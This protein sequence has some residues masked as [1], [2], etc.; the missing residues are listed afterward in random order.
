MNCSGGV[1]SNKVICLTNSGKYRIVRRKTHAIGNR[2]QGYSRPQQQLDCGQADMSYFCEKFL[3]E[4]L[5]K[6]V[7]FQSCGCRQHKTQ[8]ICLLPKHCAGI[9][10]GGCYDSLN[11]CEL[12]RLGSMRVSQS[13]AIGQTRNTWSD[14]T[15]VKQRVWAHDSN[16]ES[17][18]IP[19]GKHRCRTRLTIR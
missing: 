5:R 13:R 11:M 15:M 18:A 1:R 2:L 16:K 7:N 9:H 10:R 17:C 6:A 8:V 4:G 19:R 12:R 14:E 3:L